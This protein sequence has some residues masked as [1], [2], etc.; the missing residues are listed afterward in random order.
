MPSSGE[1]VSVVLP[2]AYLNGQLQCV[3]QVVAHNIF[4][5]LGRL[6]GMAVLSFVGANVG[7][8]MLLANLVLAAAMG[9]GCVLWLWS[10]E[11]EAHVR[12][13]SHAR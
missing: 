2:C 3:Q 13:F 11:V 1:S 12:R 10:E 9:V 6:P 7:S 5:V 8:N 4:V